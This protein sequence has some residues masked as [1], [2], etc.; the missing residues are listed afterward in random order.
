MMDFA[1]CGGLAH[2]HELDLLPLVSCNVYIK[3]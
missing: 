1:S 3:C 2:N